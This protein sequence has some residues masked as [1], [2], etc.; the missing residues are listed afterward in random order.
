[1]QNLINILFALELS[2]LFTHEMDAIRKKEWEMFIF[3]KN[4][5]D[6][7]ACNI[8]MLLHI[9]LYVVILSLLF[10]SYLNIGYYIIDMFLFGHML[11]HFGFRKHVNNKLNGIIS[12]WIINL[13]GVLAIIHFVIILI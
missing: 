7:K 13:A 5:T 3:F 4:M 8:F 1:M 6:E 11:I 2:L 10:S 9:P 12:K